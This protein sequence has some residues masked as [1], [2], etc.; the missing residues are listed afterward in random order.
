[1]GGHSNKGSLL[2]LVGNI[3]FSVLGAATVVS[4]LGG[5]VYLLWLYPQ[6]AVSSVLFLILWYVLGHK[7]FKPFFAVLE[8]R[9]AR[10]AGDEKLAQETKKEAEQLTSEIDGIL[11]QAR[12]AGISARDSEVMAAREE[13]KVTLERVKQA[14]DLELEKARASIRSNYNEERERLG[15]EAIEIGEAMV[16]KVVDRVSS[17]SIH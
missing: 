16:L 7:V 15:R 2:G 12:L 4:V 6:V 1:M 10:T 11:A 3:F 14:S 5:L 17:R 8:Q 13:A 9:E